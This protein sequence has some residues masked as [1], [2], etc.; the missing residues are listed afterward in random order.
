MILW[1][2][3][4]FLKTIAITGMI[5]LFF[6]ILEINDIAFIVWNKLMYKFLHIVKNILILFQ[7][8][9]G[10]WARHLSNTEDRPA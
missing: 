5:G 2:P 8:K 10:V 7:S 4:I 9:A 6:I 3:L 1:D